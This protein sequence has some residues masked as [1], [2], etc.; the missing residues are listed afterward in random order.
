M[1]AVVVG[2]VALVDAGGEP[3]VA[4]RAAPG[5]VVFAVAG[6]A[7]DAAAGPRLEEPLGRFLAVCLCR[8]CGGRAGV[9]VF[10]STEPAI[11]FLERLE[12]NGSC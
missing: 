3:A 2:G 5:L 12:R 1:V 8:G 11:A 10:G 6:G 9:A 4:C 7:L